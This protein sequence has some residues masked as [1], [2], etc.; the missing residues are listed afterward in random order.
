MRRLKAMER[1]GELL[2]NRRQGY[3]VASKMGSGPGRS[4]DTPMA[5]V[6]CARMMAA[7]IFSSHR[8]TCASFCTATA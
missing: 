6:F 3:G 5:M 4:L 2:R 7:A 1:D 8:A